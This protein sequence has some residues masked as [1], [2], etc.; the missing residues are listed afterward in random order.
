MDWLYFN[1]VMYRDGSWAL[2]T[3]ELTKN[4][5]IEFYHGRSI[6]EQP[7]RIV[8]NGECLCSALVVSIL[9]FRACLRRTLP[10]QKGLGVAFSSHTESYAPNLGRKLGLSLRTLHGGAS[11]SSA[12]FA[13][14]RQAA[15]L[16]LKILFA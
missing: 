11:R 4:C 10:S 15:Q 2:P 9:L 1:G 13:N 8:D 16:P 7:A 12:C 14:C 3:D 6:L 5:M